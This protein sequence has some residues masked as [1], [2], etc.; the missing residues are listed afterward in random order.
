MKRDGVVKV[1]IMDDTTAAALC[2]LSARDPKVKYGAARQILALSADDPVRLYPHLDLFIDL[3]DSQN[4]ILRW[5]AIDIIG[6]LAQVDADN[7]IDALIPRL[8]RMLSLG[9]LITTNHAISALAE[10]ALAKPQHQS[11]ITR[12][13]LNV[14]DYKFESGECLNIACGKVLLGIIKYLPQ[15]RDRRA[16]VAFAQRQTTSTRNA[17]RKKA[18]QFLKKAG[19]AE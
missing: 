2:N 8:T 11:R 19:S 5:T 14:E 15:L 13:L 6:N 10:I 18:E 1:Q 17:T 7:R 12:A 16:V 4:Q 3:L 9:S